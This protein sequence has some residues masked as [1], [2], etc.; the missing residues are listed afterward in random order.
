MNIRYY[1]ISFSAPYVNRHG[2]LCMDIW[3][4]DDG[5]TYVVVG[6]DDDGYIYSVL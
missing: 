5:I 6:I 1:K 3:A 2:V 4:G